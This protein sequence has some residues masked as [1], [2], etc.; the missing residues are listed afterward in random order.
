MTV[1][2]VSP[3]EI[4]SA[5]SAARSLPFGAGCADTWEKIQN[6]L[7]IAGIPT[8]ARRL[9][10]AE[11][12]WQAAAFLDGS[13]EVLPHHATVLGNVLWTD[14][15]HADTVI[16]ICALASAEN[17]E[18][19]LILL[20]SAEAAADDVAEQIQNIRSGISND[21]SAVLSAQQ[22]VMLCAQELRSLTGD[23]PIGI[24]RDHLTRVGEIW[25][26]LEDVLRAA[27][28]A[29]VRGLG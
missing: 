19:S 7:D 18:Q 20:D 23:N 25:K 9:K 6:G 15:D 27:K 1:P 28:A 5:K 12:V 24:L 11:T 29:L 2:T 17:A 26:E 4:E 16:R 3:S 22:S 14:L 21:H 8:S 10:Q 13:S